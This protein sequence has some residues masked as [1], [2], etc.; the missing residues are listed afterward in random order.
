MRLRSLLL[1]AAIATLASAQLTMTS[2]QVVTFIRSSIQLHHDDRKVAEYVKK[3]KLKDKLEDRKVEELQGLGA[4]PR[5]LAALKELS[6]S[7]EALPDAPPPAPVVPRPTIPPPDSVEQ[8]EILHDIIDNAR[9]YAKTLPDYMCIQV[10]RR[11]ADDSGTENWRMLDTIQEQLSYVDHKESYKVVMYNG[12]SVANI[13]HGQLGGSTSSGEFGSIFTEIFA[14]ETATDFNWD[15]WATLRGKRM[16]VFAFTVPQSRS[17]YTIYSGDVHRTITAGYHGLIYADRDTK[18]V[19]RYKMEC[20]NIPVD[21]PVKDI[22][23]DVNYDY[24]DIAGSK[25][26]LPLKTEI[27][28]RDGKYMSWNE[29][30]FH[31]YRKF[32][33]DATIKF[34]TDPEPVPADQTEE[35]PATPDSKDKKPEVKKKP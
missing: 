34:D 21:F 9:N 20:D 17:H 16:Y 6:A 1:A 28:A 19:M 12:Q 30:E 33:A 8:A 4:G 29:S 31:L 5:T 35:K 14:P 3:I 2:D 7:S 11:R 18:M 22:K 25:Y 15:H 26:V 32:S 23:L 10:T 24:T 27:R 13:Q